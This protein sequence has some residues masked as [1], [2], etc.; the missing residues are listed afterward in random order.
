MVIDIYCVSAQ[1]ESAAQC[2]DAQKLPI[3]SKQ[4]LRNINIRMCCDVRTK[5]NYQYEVKQPLRLFLGSFFMGNPDPRTTGW[6]KWIHA[7]M[8]SL[9]MAYARHRQTDWAWVNITSTLSATRRGPDPNRPTRRTFFLKTG[10]N[11]YS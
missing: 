5:A 9:R 7:K 6:H 2:A 8:I 11:P 10:T 4:E 3:T 1:C